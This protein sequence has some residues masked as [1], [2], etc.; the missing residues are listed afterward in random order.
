MNREYY[1]PTVLFLSVICI[2]K[3]V[4]VISITIIVFT[5]NVSTAGKQTKIMLHNNGRVELSQSKKVTAS[6]TTS[7]IFFKVVESIYWQHCV[8]ALSLFI[9]T[10]WQLIWYITCV[11]S[12]ASFIM[13]VIRTCLRVS[14][15]QY[16]MTL[17][18]I[19]MRLILNR[20]NYSSHI[21]EYVTEPLYQTL[22]A[23]S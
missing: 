10:S 21:S 8:S 17:I 16:V 19:F 11:T 7:K 2:T 12:I 4:I 5:K 9:L 6:K 20:Q 18:R 3:Q 22:Q 13:I 14:R 23:C 15:I 1:L